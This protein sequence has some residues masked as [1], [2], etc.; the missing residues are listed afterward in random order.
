[1]RLAILIALLWALLPTVAHAAPVL[2][3]AGMAAETAAVVAAVIQIG[4]TVGMAVYG[5]AQQRRAEQAARDKYNASLKDR[6]ITAVQ[7]DS[8]YRYV[9]GRAR[10]GSAVVAIF[11][12]GST[13]QYKHLVCVHAAHECDAIEEVYIAGKA[14]G[15][16]D[17]N[18]QVTSGDYYKMSTVSQTEVKSGAS[19]TLAATP[20]ASSLVV[21]KDN[22][23]D[24]GTFN[25][26]YTLSGATVTLSQ[27]YGTVTCQYTVTSNTSTVRVQKH[28]GV[29]NDPVD[30]YLH[31]LLPTDW[32]TTATLDGFCYTVITL[33]LNQAEFQGGIPTIEVLLRGK[34]LYDPRTSTTAWSQNPA[35]AI[36]DYLQSEMC[37]VP[38]SDIPTADVITAANVCDTVVSG[39]SISGSGPLYT[40]NGSVTADEDQAS[41][42]EKMAQAMAGGIVATTW[43]MWA[44]SYVAPVMNLYVDKSDNNG[45][46]IGQ[47]AITPGMPDA[48]TFNGVKGQFVG[49]SNSYVATDFPPY[50]NSTYVTADGGVEKWTNIDFP[51]TDDPQ[52]VRNLCCIYTNDQRNG[53]TVKA[54]FSLKVWS[55]KIGDRVTLT[56]TLF[57]WSAKIFRVTDKKYSPSTGIELTLKEDASTIW[58]LADAVTADLTPNS[59][60]PNPFYL[61]PLTSLTCTSGNNDLLLAQDGTVISRIHVTWPAAT[62]AAVVHGGEIEVQWQLVGATAWQSILASGDATD[63]YLSPVRDKMTY[64]IRARTIDKY[65][66]VKSNW[67]YT[68]HLVQG[69]SAPPAD[70]TGFTVTLLSD[71]MRRFS[72]DTSNQSVDVT[73]G[74]GYRI[75]YRT[76]GSGTTWANMT[77]IGEGLLTQ[78]PYDSHD[79]V[80]GTYDF[81]ICAVD[82]SGNESANAEIVTN[83]TISD[84]STASTALANAATAQDA[85]NAANDE[86]ANIANDNIL[87]K[88][89]KIILVRDVNAI[90]DEFVHNR[91]QADSL[92]V[93]RTDYDMAVWALWDY[94]GTLAPSYDNLSSDT[95]IDGPTLRQ[96]FANVYTARQVMLNEI[97]T[98]AST[99]ATWAGVTGSGK[100]A[101]NATVGATFG[102]DVNGQITSSNA[103]TYIATGALGTT[104]IATDAV[105]AVLE[106]STSSV[107][108][109]N[110][111]SA[112]GGPTSYSLF[113]TILTIAYTAD[114]DC[115]CVATVT[116]ASSGT[117]T[118]PS[119]LT[120]S[121]GWRYQDRID[122]NETFAYSD[123]HESI[124]PVV[125][126]YT[127]NS[128]QTD[129]AN[130]SMFRKFSLTSGQSVTFY[131]RVSSNDYSFMT[132]TLNK[133]L[134]RVEVIKR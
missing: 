72:W 112:A 126:K 56:S 107:S 100:P 128:S 14:L 119:T 98:Q 68:T 61:N 90:M 82:A 78:T 44:G 35:L 18:G 101:D 103:G 10:V 95:T 3:A 19:F 97:A 133:A 110:Q 27:D 130:Q 6:A 17:S 85:A 123:N 91:L 111:N 124:P 21:V 30:A 8:P 54:D 115:E 134:M 63:I 65:L 80:A 51:W 106:T 96:K 99:L 114:S 79:P 1:M 77:Q 11:T 42:L 81:A 76:A 5:A 122:I 26:S 116:S 69:K 125:N 92:S 66:N 34:K 40:L 53:Y 4:L 60:L 86:L 23:G 36:Y 58:N 52:R 109:T 120:G 12:S 62:D 121:P 89:E 93:S 20:D 83:V 29:A 13:D 55:L 2:I 64:V 132:W 94:L 118:V 49:A 131:Y 117:G 38:A 9:Y 73:H 67:I 22:G 25:P 46:V 104:Q 28:L 105:T 41:V 74:G 127:L 43:S 16:L 24:S 15:T 70:V 33:D 113:Q 57:G 39:A 84:T 7:G 129:Y 47:I 59:N 71:A 31:G 102:V 87:S 108:L 48:D 88:G 45:D 75:K 32:P 37:G 50:Q